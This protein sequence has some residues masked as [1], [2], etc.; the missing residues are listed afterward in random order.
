MAKKARYK[1]PKYAGNPDSEAKA[2]IRRITEEFEP[3][4]YLNLAE[5]ADDLYEYYME[6]QPALD[7]WAQID[8]NRF[9]DK[10]PQIFTGEDIDYLLRFD[11]GKGVVIGAVMALCAAEDSIQDQIDARGDDEL[12]EADLELMVIDGVGGGFGGWGEET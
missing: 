1:V 5:L 11:T 7:A 10:I 3:N 9:R 6:L 8:Q 12:S 2:L 4:K